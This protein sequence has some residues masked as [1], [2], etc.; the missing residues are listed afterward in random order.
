MTVPVA[1][2]RP[3]PSPAARVLQAPD[4]PARARTVRVRV[5]RNPVGI[6]VRVA[7]VADSGAAIADRRFAV[8]T[9]ASFRKRWFLLKQMPEPSDVSAYR[10]LGW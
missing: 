4:P 3:A 6:V 9:I 1:R 10:R 8:E 7:A 5:A 2:A